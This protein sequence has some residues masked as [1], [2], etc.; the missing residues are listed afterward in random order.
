[1][2]EEVRS[3]RG[4]DLQIFSN[5]GQEQAAKIQDQARKYVKGP[6]P[7][8]LFQAMVLVTVY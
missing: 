1:M 2:Y 7:H 8:R 3:S 4:A 5:T 6:I